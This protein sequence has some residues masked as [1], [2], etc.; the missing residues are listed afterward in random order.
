[1]TYPLLTINKA[2]IEHNTETLSN[3]LLKQGIRLVGVAK[4]TCANLAVVEAMISGGADAIGDSRIDNLIKLREW[5]YKG[6]TVLLR[7]PGPSQCVQTVMYADTSLNSE[8]DT[9]KLLG[10]AASKTGQMHKVVLMVDL[11]D[12]REGVM[13]EQAPQVAFEMDQTEGID[14]VGIGT[15]LAC[16]GGVIPTVEKMTLLIEVKNAIE[17]R[18]ENSSGYQEERLQIS[19]WPWI[20]K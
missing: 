5:G 16:Y 10:E 6:E 18:K 15:N 14:L 9:V 13:V 19:G 8:V 12:L 7:A 20:S 11:G 2:K 17:K 3:M 4:G 1:M